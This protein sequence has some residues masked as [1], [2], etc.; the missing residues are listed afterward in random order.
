MREYYMIRLENF[1]NSLFKY[2]DKACKYSYSLYLHPSV[3]VCFVPFICLDS[4]NSAFSLATLLTCIDIV[5]CEVIT[6]PPCLNTIIKE[7]TRI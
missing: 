4:Y 1:L 5:F 3:E 6:K 2:F 7:C